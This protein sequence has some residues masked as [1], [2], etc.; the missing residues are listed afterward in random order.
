M[1]GKTPQEGDLLQGKLQISL[2]S[3]FSSDGEI[4]EFK[5][6]IVVEG[7][8]V[9]TSLL[10]YAMQAKSLKGTMLFSPKQGIPLWKQGEL[11][12]T[13]EGTSFFA[14]TE[15]GLFGIQE[16]LGEIRMHPEE[17][18]Y[19]KALGTVICNDNAIPFEIE[20]SG[21]PLENGAYWMQSAARFFF[22][23]Q[24]P[25]LVLS[26]CQ[27]NEKESAIQAEFHD[28]GP[29]LYELARTIAASFF[30]CLVH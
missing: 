4:K 2:E 12:L 3:A 8:D 22:K 28:I 9:Q 7:L 5:A 27:N 17:D 14:N 11:F 26:L 24:E 20:G 23:G 15:K 10:N 18:P 25:T 1:Q 6:H 13:F 19:I 16:S 29:E 30:P 21:E